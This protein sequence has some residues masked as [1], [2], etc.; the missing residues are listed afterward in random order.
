MLFKRIMRI[1]G[2]AWVLPEVSQGEEG[3]RDGWS[4][5]GQST[6]RVGRSHGFWASV[7]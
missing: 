3:G 2:P 4:G 5:G 1:K 6:L 7:P